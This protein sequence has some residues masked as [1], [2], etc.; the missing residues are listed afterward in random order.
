MTRNFLDLARIETGRLELDLQPYDLVAD[1]VRP[2]MQELEP[3]ALRR[4]MRVASELPDNLRLR[5]DANL[6]RV[7]V[8]NLL[9]NAL[10]Y[11]RRDGRVLV[12][13]GATGE[14]V[15]LEVW[16]EGD[17][18]RPEQIAQLFSKFRRFAGGRQD[19]PRGSGLGLF[20][21]SEILARHGGTIAAE[22]EPGAWMRFVVSLPVSG[23]AQDEAAAPATGPADCSTPRLFDYT[24]RLPS[25]ARSIVISSAYSRSLPTGTPIAMRVTLTPSGF[26]RRAR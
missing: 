25:I 13:A 16:N 9:G 1:V 21:V 22:S 7:V 17:G 23:P 11:G 10:R 5:A 6:L 18:L 14:T 19:A 4:S 12:S 20:I 15:W 3:E 24:S 8:R 2:V 26:N